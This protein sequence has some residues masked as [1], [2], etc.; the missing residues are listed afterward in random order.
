MK[1]NIRYSVILGANI[2]M[3]LLFIQGVSAQEKYQLNS[4]S[5]IVIEGT[6]NLH[7]WETEATKINGNATLTVEQGKVKS[8]ENVNVKIPVKSIES[9]KG[10]M[11]GKT[12]DAL[13]ADDNPEIS[14]GLDQVEMTAPNK[15]TIKGD[16]NIAGVSRPVE[17]QADYKVDGSSIA[18]QGKLPILMS[19]FKVKPPTALF[20]TLKTGDQVMIKY[21]AVFSK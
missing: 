21:N 13:K 19:D 9:G 11:D 20:G 7:D 1:T 14:F 16:L 10:T 8:I 18:F 4:S 12:Y 15:V 5:K 6:S 2:L 3:C 17:L